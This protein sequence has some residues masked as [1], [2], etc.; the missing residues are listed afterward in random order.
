[1]TGPT[2]AEVAE[3]DQAVAYLGGRVDDM[4]AAAGRLTDEHGAERAVS[5]VFQLLMLS[6]RDRVAAIAAVALVRLAGQKAAGGE[7]S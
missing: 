4:A 1:M 7:Q 3:L 6:R 2:P 5:A